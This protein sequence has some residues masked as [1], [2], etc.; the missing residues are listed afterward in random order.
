MISEMIHPLGSLDCA[1][2]I[3]IDY[4]TM[5]TILGNENLAMETINGIPTEA[6][7]NR[8]VLVK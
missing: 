5:N 1:Y 2:A 8:Y 6:R 4:I 7:S 3:N